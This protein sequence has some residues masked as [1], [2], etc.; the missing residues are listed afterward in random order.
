[1]G[2]VSICLYWNLCIVIVSTYYAL[3]GFLCVS[4]PKSYDGVSNAWN[5]SEILFYIFVEQQA[6]M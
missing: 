2:V 3:L 1:M 6:L 4:C 5:G